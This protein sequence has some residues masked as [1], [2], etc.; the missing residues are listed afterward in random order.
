M[1]AE[2]KGKWLVFQSITSQEKSWL[3]GILTWTPDRETNEEPETLL[4]ERNGVLFTLWGLYRILKQI[5]PF[6][7]D[8]SGI[9]N[10]QFERVFIPNTILPG[11]KLFDFQVAAA[12]KSVSWKVGLVNV[13]TGGGKTEIIL[14][15]LRNLI[16]TGKLTRG[17]VIVPSVGL[18]DQFAERAYLRG[19]SKDE[20]G[21]VHGSSKEYGS[22][23]VV[24]VVNSINLGL[25]NNNEI[26][27]NLVSNINTIIYDETH[28]L[29]ASTYMNIAIAASKAKYF[30]GYSGSPYSGDDNSILENSGD[31][32]VYGMTGG[33]IF[34]ISQRYVRE[35]GLIAEP[36]IFFKEIAEKTSRHITQYNAIYVK[37]VIEHV[38]RNE[39][40]VY[41][42]RKF[43]SLGFPTLILVQRLDHAR[44]IMSKLKGLRVIS[45]FGGGTSLQ[46]G[47]FGTIDEMPVDYNIFRS[48]FELG[49]FDVVIA[50]QVLDEGFDIPAIGAVILA[51]GGKSKIKL[52]Q[53]IGRGLRRKKKGPNKVYILDFWDKQHVFM[54]SQ[55]K[56]RLK[57]MTDIE[58]TII[59]D[60]FKFMEMIIEHSKEIMT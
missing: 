53:R 51:G 24:A 9:P 4:Y 15:V 41:Y 5:C 46:F 38:T 19:F 12:I 6:E 56:K 13:P 31:A 3:S 35:L 14:A 16:D 7:F 59:P 37:N 28:H 17:L 57:L 26:I 60:Q 40:I 23:V 1:R 20:V 44:N 18:A 36:I 54:L 34:N 39:Y 42:A 11:I 33:V 27:T 32:L 55:S 21:V 10:D 22:K 45:V 48:N 8:V 50:S 2:I 52:L 49:M 25:K 30:L 47:E 29:K 43:T 58:A